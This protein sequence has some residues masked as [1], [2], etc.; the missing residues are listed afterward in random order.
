MGR[1]KD[2]KKKET[3]KG[4]G[5]I[6]AV[7]EMYGRNAKWVNWA[8][9]GLLFVLAFYVR[10]NAI[11]GKTELHSDEV[12]SMALCTCDP[13]Y[14]VAVADGIYTGA[15]LKDMI[16]HSGD[17]GFKGMLSDLRQLWVNNGD[18]PHASLYYM[19]LRVALTGYDAYDLDGYI[20][21]GGVLNMLFFVLSFVFMYKLLRR[22]FGER[23]MLVFVGLALA[24]FNL[25]S[26][27][28]T[29]LIREYQMAE[30]S[31][32][33]LTYVAVGFVQRLRAG[34]EIRRWRFV[35]LFGVLMGCTVSLGYFNAFYVIGLCLALAA[36]CIRHHRHRA[37]LLILLAGVAALVFAFV[38]YPG[39][40]NFILHPTVHK[41]M[42]FR[43]FSLALSV[44]FARDIRRLLFISYGFWIVLAAVLVAAFSK[45]GLKKLADGGLFVWLP[46]LVVA[47]MP[48]IQYASILKHPRYYYCL[49]PVLMLLV[50]Q[51]LAAMPNLWRRYFGILILLFFPIFTP[52]IHFRDNYRWDAVRKEL[53]R[54]VIFYQLNPNEL[55]QFVPNLDDNVE[56]TV[57]GKT[58][59]TS[60]ISQGEERLVV[61]KMGKIDSDKFV[62]VGKAI[63]NSNIYLFNV[64][65]VEK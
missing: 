26:V 29:M 56:Y 50:P 34:E 43:K 33:M 54:P 23:H 48:L 12:F 3:G 15:Q 52:Q 21:R 47:C 11:A 5:A 9:V 27:R 65:Y 42:A 28:N 55:I 40:F 13:N 16:A 39:F 63:W 22:I 25:L 19:A 30:A 32:V 53:A 4:L 46:L 49:M 2:N 20:V 64:K 8:I 44:T 58:P 6:T 61:A 62:F 36:S 45:G 1:N 35:A 60:E 37:I 59:M 10:V 17:T 38:I 14:N 18:A 31:V 41:S 24:Y 51:S 57:M 7:T